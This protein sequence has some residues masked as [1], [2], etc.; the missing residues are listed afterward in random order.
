MGRAALIA[1]RH[2]RDGNG[3]AVFMKA[4]IATARYYAECLLPQAP[5][6]AQTIIGGGETALALS[7]EQ[8]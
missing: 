5:G 3:D 1:A 7:A 4:K 2:L 8:F 6:L